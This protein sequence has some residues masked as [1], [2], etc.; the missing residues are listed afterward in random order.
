MNSAVS[1]LASVERL[2]LSVVIIA[3]NEAANI[4]DCIQSVSFATQVV[5]L[6]GGSTD[7]TVAL[8]RKAGAQVVVE[9]DWQGFGPQKNRALAL[10]RQSWVL[11]LDA[12]ERV[13]PALAAEIEQFIRV[14]PDNV[15]AEIPRLTQFC[16]QWIRHCGWYPDRVRRLWPRGKCQF[17]DDL[18]HERLVTH[19]MQVLRLKLPLLHYSYPSPE[20]YWN[21]L[22]QYSQAWALQRYTQGKTTS[23]ARAAASGCLAFMRSYVLRLGFLDG[24]LGFAVCVMQAQAAFGKYFTLY[25]LH[26]QSM[27]LP[28]VQD[29]QAPTS[30]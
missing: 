4:T 2:D 18:V 24:G 22:S 27:T 5:V 13:T 19:E 14:H 20:H 6:D 28:L 29:H 21:K 17:S 23:I 8:A 15:V 16:G 1:H 12:D 3:L 26:R 10:A 30:T 25:C 7:D 11:S 9:P